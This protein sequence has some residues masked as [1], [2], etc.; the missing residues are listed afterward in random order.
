MYNGVEVYLSGTNAAWIQYGYD[1]GNNQWEQ[2]TKTLWEENIRLLGDGGANS[3]RVWLH[4]EG[5][6]RLGI[7]LVNENLLQ[8]FLTHTKELT[9]LGPVFR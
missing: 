1:F 9:H 5:E 2:S 6:S 8:T 4:V 3:I 7:A